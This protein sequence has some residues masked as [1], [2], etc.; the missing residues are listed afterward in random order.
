MSIYSNLITSI[1]EVLKFQK[2]HIT[3]PK[4]QVHIKC[5]LCANT[6]LPVGTIYHSS[7]PKKRKK[8]ITQLL[9]STN[10][11]ESDNMRHSLHW[12]VAS[13]LGEKKNSC[14]S[15]K[16]HQAPIPLLPPRTFAFKKVHHYKHHT[17]SLLCTTLFMYPWFNF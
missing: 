17:Q 1:S 6:K 14:N 7:F 9:N 16:D 8:Y 3:M 11:R 10:L 2:Q 15:P 4:N 13:I 5:Q 12:H